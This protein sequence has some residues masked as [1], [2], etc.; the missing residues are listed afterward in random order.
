MKTEKKF[1]NVMTSEGTAT[2]L[3][4]GD[5]GVGD[6][7][8]SGRI[9]SELLAL[10]KQYGKIEVRINSRGGDVFS[11]MAI[12][13]ALRQS[14]TD[15]TIYIDGLAAS[16]SAIIALCG[17]PLYMS[18]Y[19]RL[20]LHSVSCYVSGNASELRETA[21]QIENLQKSLASMIA[22]RCGMTAEEVLSRY[23]D[24]ADHYLSAQEALEMKLIDG[25]YDMPEGEKPASDSD[26]DIYTYF[27][28]RLSTESQNKKNMAL[29]NDIQAL[30]TFKDMADE[31]AILAHIKKLESKAA[32]ADALEQAN[33]SYK[34]RIAQLEAKEI[35]TFLDQAVSEGK[36]TA[37]QKPMYEKLMASD[38]TATE[39]LINSM[40]PHAMRRATSFID[41]NGGKSGSFE[42]KTWDELDKENRLAEL[43]QNNY[44]L[45]KNKYK[46]RFGV[47]YKD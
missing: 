23:F 31:G 45:F 21:T 17:K 18:P 29:I 47:E 11:G 41:T 16:I 4:Y 14:R 2:L 26:N 38:R 36:I 43:K 44:E 39:E 10:Q 37:E 42:D 19:A 35:T 24:G 7:V 6:T 28:N 34:N 30:P 9:V 22:G 20:M 3:L 13:N 15:I 32:N 46:E 33:N 40:K 8:D 5:V 27:N 12:Y 25:I 1:F